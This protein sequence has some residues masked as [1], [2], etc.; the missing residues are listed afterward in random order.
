MEM[1]AP[2]V[3]RAHMTQLARD[4]FTT[5]FS[6]ARSDT[7]K[8]ASLQFLIAHRGE[9]LRLSR[10]RARARRQAARETAHSAAWLL[11]GSISGLM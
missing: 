4:Q 7:G 3:S 5:L 2:V 9:L 1:F 8:G 11:S 10:R 6:Q